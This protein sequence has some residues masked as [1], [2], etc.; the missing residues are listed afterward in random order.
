MRG[1]GNGCRSKNYEPNS[2]ND[3]VQTNEPHDKPIAV[4][5]VTGAQKQSLHSADDDFSQGGDLY[6]VMSKDEKAR[7]I[8]NIAGNLSAVK[9]DDIIARSIDHFRKADN[10]L[11]AQLEKRIKELR[12]KNKGQEVT[13]QQ[14][15]AT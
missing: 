5:G 1:D 2:F 8:E 4:Q 6:R 9:R 13:I 10:D 11:G 3:P 12:M 14:S 15:A 7:L